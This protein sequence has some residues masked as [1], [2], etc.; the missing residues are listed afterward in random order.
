MGLGVVRSVVVVGLNK[1]N[2]V[3]F[4]DTLNK[5]GPGKTFAVYLTDD[6]ARSSL[7]VAGVE[8]DVTISCIGFTFV[9]FVDCGVGFAEDAG[10]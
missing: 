8:V 6:Q 2:T 7:V 9:G 10:V 1:G 5:I 4:G 3:T